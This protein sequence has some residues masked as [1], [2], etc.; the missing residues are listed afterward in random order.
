MEPQHTCAASLTFSPLL[1]NLLFQLS[2]TRLVFFLAS[3][4]KL[5]YRPQKI[6]DLVGHH[7]SREEHT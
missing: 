2:R 1:Q 3:F 5:L 6:G 4:F 7:E